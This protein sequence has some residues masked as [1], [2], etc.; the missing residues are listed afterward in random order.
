MATVA[1]M[2]GSAMF[3][4]LQRLDRRLKLGL[5]RQVRHSLRRHDRS[6]W[7][8]LSAE[9]VFSQI[10]DRHLWGGTSGFHSGSGSH[11]PKIVAP[12]LAAVRGWMAGQGRLDAVDLGCG[13]FH[14][15]GQLRDLFG[16]YVACDVV[17][18]LIAHHQ[19]G[20]FAATVDFRC[21]DLARDPLPPGDV[22]FV[23]Q[24]LQHL[25]N[26]MIAALAPKLD[27]YRW[28]VL[29]EHVPADPAHPRNLDKP[30]GPDTRLRLGSGVDLCAAPFNLQVRDA[31][32][33]CEVPQYGG[34]IR[35]TLYQ[36]RD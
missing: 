1:G 7:E 27:A 22:V 32:V 19:A 25:T 12:Y 31:R 18:A 17:P 28:L 33:L 2:D 10:Y 3:F 6:A 35:T 8:G 23:R 9:Q 36:L 24:V 30:M 13:D 4:W 34:L 14:V 21:L 11:D 5:T 20:P 16:R 15:G 26:A 29:T